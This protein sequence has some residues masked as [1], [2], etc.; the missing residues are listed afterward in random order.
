MPI[1][2]AMQRYAKPDKQGIVSLTESI[3]AKHGFLG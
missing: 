2:S 1:L 3:T